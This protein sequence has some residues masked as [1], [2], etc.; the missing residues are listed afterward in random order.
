MSEMNEKNYKKAPQ[1]LKKADSKKSQGEQIQTSVFKSDMI[2]GKKSIA[3]DLGQHVK[4]KRRLPIAVD[5]IAGIFML[6]LVCA[7][8]VGTYMLFRYYSNDYEGTD[9][10]YTVEISLNNKNDAGHYMAMKNK[11]VFMDKN[12]NA[13]FFGKIAGVETVENADRIRLVIKADAKYRRGEGYSIGDT[14]V[15][16]GSRFTLRCGEEALNDVAVVEL[17]GG[18]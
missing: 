7:V 1:D 8:I 9:I 14:K 12:S 6:A 10:T 11:E 3:S 2:V 16:V 18:N 15:A 5:I 4:V 17:D 13:V